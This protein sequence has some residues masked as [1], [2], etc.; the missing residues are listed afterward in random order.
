MKTNSS[1]LIL[2]IFNSFSLYGQFDNYE[3]FPVFLPKNDIEYLQNGT[4]LNDS[5]Y[6]TKERI[7]NI[8]T[9]ELDSLP[10]SIIDIF[11]GKIIEEDNFY[12]LGSLH[13]SSNFE[14]YIFMVDYDWPWDIFRGFYMINIQKN[15][16]LSVFRISYYMGDWSSSTHLF[17]QFQSPNIL[18]SERKM[19]VHDIDYANDEDRPIERRGDISTYKITEE[20]YIDFE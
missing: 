7:K 3:Y 10:K 19:K 18:T 17:T 20:G 6:F 2:F 14:T 15:R 1:F 16:L 8:K 12:Y 13:V 5:I 11:I 9:N 4:L